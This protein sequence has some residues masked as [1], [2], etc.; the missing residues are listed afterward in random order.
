MNDAIVCG[1]VDIPASM[2]REI[3]ALEPFQ[4]LK[5]EKER[6]LGLLLALHPEKLKEKFFELYDT[7]GQV[8]IFAITKMDEECR[9]IIILEINEILG[10]KPF[11]RLTIPTSG[12]SC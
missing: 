2:L 1:G 10:V 8:D 12:V 7:Q 3:L 4:V 5:S 11:K 9:E 6:H